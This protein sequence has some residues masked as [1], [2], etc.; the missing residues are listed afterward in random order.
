MRQI[1]HHEWQKQI[2]RLERGTTGIEAKPF[3]IWC[4]HLQLTRANYLD[5]CRWT[6]TMWTYEVEAVPVAASGLTWPPHFPAPFDLVCHS[7]TISPISWAFYYTIAYHV[8]TVAEPRGT[9]R[10]KCALIIS[11]YT[12][13]YAPI[14][15]DTRQCKVW[16]TPVES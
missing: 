11:G 5:L 12:P 14:G 10:L 4:A 9:W 8:V 15:P 7:T 2:W 6:S 1:E 13:T 16:C 3:F